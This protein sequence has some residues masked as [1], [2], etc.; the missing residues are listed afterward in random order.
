[1]FYN[2]ITIHKCKRF[3]LNKTSTITITPKQ[4]TVMVLGRN[5]CGKSSFVDIGLSILP[6]DRRQFSKGGYREQEIS[7]NG[8]EYF[9]KSAHNGDHVYKKNDEVLYEG[10]V[11]SVYRELIQEEFGINQKIHDVLMAKARHTFT[12][13]SPM[14]ERREWI[15]RLSKSDFNYVLGFYDR[16]RKESRAIGNVIKHQT[17]RLASETSK[18]MDSEELEGI[19]SRYERAQD[20]LQELYGTMGQETPI[21]M[22]KLAHHLEGTYRELNEGARWLEA[23][24]GYKPLP[25]PKNGTQ[26]TNYDELRNHIASNEAV[27]SRI[28]DQITELSSQEDRLSREYK[29]LMAKSDRDPEELRKEIAEHRKKIEEIE[30]RTM[31]PDGV[32]I[33]DTPQTELDC[34]RFIDLIRNLH[35]GIDIEEVGDRNDIVRGLND[36]LAQVEGQ[37]A[38]IEANIDHYE[39]CQSVECPACNH[40]F[41]P[42]ISDETYRSNLTTRMD[43]VSKRDKIHEKLGEQREWFNEYRVVKTNL[44]NIR[45][46]QRNHGLLSRLWTMIEDIGGVTNTQET[47]QVATRYSDAIV[48]SRSHGKLIV[49][50][51]VCESALEACVDGTQSGPLEARIK[52][53]HKQLNDLQI[54]HRELDKHNRGATRALRLRDEFR[55]QMERMYAQYERLGKIVDAVFVNGE[56]HVL[57]QQIAGLQHELHSLKNTISGAEVQLGIVKDIQDQLDDLAI[58]ELHYKVLEQR[59]SPSSGYIAELISRDIGALLDVMNQLIA[60]V[61]SYPITLLNCTADNG[62]LNYRFPM[63]VGAHG[64]DVDDISQGSSSQTDIINFAFRLLVHKAMEI[65]NYP[66][67]ID[68]LERAFDGSHKE[69]LHQAIQSLIKDDTWGQ[70]FIISH[71]TDSMLS[72]TNVEYVVLDD[73]GLQLPVEYNQNVVI[74]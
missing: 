57:K 30:S 23:N 5:G 49:A 74:K 71:N 47:L 59:L 50:L 43:L 10:K 34:K 26:I 1:M 73:Q 12:A 55:R 7:Y 11:A 53:L 61:W 13:M 40:E 16:V 2:R 3:G 66:L 67:I 72:Y 69:S 27:M 36:Q 39:S 64:N 20:A 45:D 63:V 65:S 44:T 62:D 48:D 28:M 15:T 33:P 68:E 51:A 8:N 38:R 52:A 19:K 9:L 35:I 37:L 6:I 29:D 31:F 17:G 46:F 22:R 41:R 70:V 60:S 18:L 21:E 58:K 4:K 14:G 25:V 54:E 56:H 42:G 24:S 32:S